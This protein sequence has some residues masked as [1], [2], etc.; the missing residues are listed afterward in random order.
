MPRACTGTRCRAGPI[1]CS[2]GPWSS[3]SSKS[4]LRAAPDGGGKRRKNSRETVALA[5]RIHRHRSPLLLSSPP[6]RS[7]LL[8]TLSLSLSFRLPP[9][10][11]PTLDSSLG[12]SRPAPRSFLGF[13]LSRGRG[14]GMDGEATISGYVRL[15]DSFFPRSTRNK[16]LGCE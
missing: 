5:V 16:R 3:R 1:S 12:F 9:P 8:F 13:L 2:V 14:G 11:P 15:S 7:L 10:P 6:H 4:A